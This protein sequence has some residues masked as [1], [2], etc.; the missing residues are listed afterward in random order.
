MAK[1]TESPS[2][3]PQPSIHTHSRSEP[4]REETLRLRGGYATYSKESMVELVEQMR[5]A[6]ST[7]F[8]ISLNKVFQGQEGLSGELLLESLARV[9][10]PGKSSADL[11]DILSEASLKECNQVTRIYFEPPTP[12]TLG[13]ILGCPRGSEAVGEGP[14]FVGDKGLVGSGSLHLKL[15]HHPLNQAPP[16]MAVSYCLGD[17]TQKTE[18]TCNGRTLTITA[19]DLIRWADGICIN[20]EDIHE[21]ASQVMLMGEIYSMA[22]STVAYL[23]EGLAPDTKIGR[24]PDQAGFAI[25]QQLNAIWGADEDPQT[26]DGL[27]VWVPL[28][29][30]CSQPWFSRTWILQEVALAINVLVLYGSAVTRL[31]TLTR[32]WELATRRD[33]P[34]ALRH[35]TIADWKDGLESWNQLNVFGKMR[36]MKRVNGSVDRL[37]HQP[38]D[39][40][41]VL[42]GGRRT[43]QSLLNLLVENRAAGAT[44][45]RDKVYSLFSMAGDTKDLSIEPNY[46]PANSAAKLYRDVAE[47]YIEAGRGIDILHHAGLPQRLTNLPSWVPDWSTKSRQPLHSSQYRCTRDTIP[48]LQLLS[49]EY[50][51]IRGAFVDAANVLLHKLDLQRLGPVTDPTVLSGLHN[52]MSILENDPMFPP[53][54]FVADRDRSFGAIVAHAEQMALMLLPSYPTGESICIAVWRTLVAGRGWLMPDDPDGERLAHAA[55]RGARPDPFDNAWW[56]PH[57]LDDAAREAIWPFQAVVLKT[58]QGYRFGITACGYMGLFPKECEPVRPRRNHPGSGASFTLVG[59]CYIHGMMRGELLLPSRRGDVQDAHCIDVRYH[60]RQPAWT[61]RSNEMLRLRL[62]QYF[63]PNVNRFTPLR[64][65][66][67]K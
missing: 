2:A 3:A 39:W 11:Q 19:T 8:Q 41:F 42:D 17:A 36:A 62:R 6:T 51:R 50:L 65:I 1:Q 18:I 26:T 37:I 40:G 13:D 64:D 44:D 24:E 66:D 56:P 33:L 53:L 49:N 45:Y 15:T 34:P 54:P 4:V 43:S 10:H 67:I 14:L 25:M 47:A 32:F 55:W 57:P 27:N 7:D 58:G 60:I 29:H 59:D 61:V 48:G 21:R 28:L 30:L 12:A 9:N 46:S 22:Q 35:G 5:H 23:G 16:F 20:Q 52:K 63:D 38:G 31:E